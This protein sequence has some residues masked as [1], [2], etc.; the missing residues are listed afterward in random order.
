MLQVSDGFCFLV[1]AGQLARSCMRPGEDHLER[2][3]PVQLRVAGFVD[4]AAAA[5]AQLRQN[6]ITG[7][8]RQRQF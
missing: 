5:A 4:D 8:R 3:Q 1:E 6:F 2:H 7:R